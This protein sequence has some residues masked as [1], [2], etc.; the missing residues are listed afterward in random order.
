MA[1][2]SEVR[3]LEDGQYV[4]AETF[5]RPISELAS[6]TDY[7]KNRLDALG[8]LYTNIQVQVTLVAD[9]TPAVG[10]IVCV[11]PDTKYFRKAIASMDLYDAF[12]ASEK[13]FAVGILVAKTALAGTVILYGKVNLQD[14]PVDNMTEDP[15]FVNGQY[16]LSSS[17]PGKITRFPTG[18][19]ILLGFF[20]R[21]QAVA[22]P[23]SG[24]FA[25]LNPQHMDIEAH[26]HRTYVLEPR[27]AGS[28]VEENGEVKVIG[29]WPNGFEPVY[30]SNDQEEF[31]GIPR[32][33]IAGDY[34]S[35]DEATYTVTLQNVD[36]DKPTKWP[37]QIKWSAE[38]VDEG[39]GVSTIRFFGDEAPIGTL[40]MTVR[41]EPSAHMTEDSPYQGDDGYRVWTV[42]RKIARGWSDCSIH[43]SSDFGSNIVAFAGYPDEQKNDIKIYIPKKVYDLTKL[44]ERG[45][46]LMGM[47]IVIDGETFFFGDVDTLD[48]EGKTKILV[49]QDVYETMVALAQKCNKV[50]YDEKLKQALCI[51]D[52]ETPVAVTSQSNEEH[53]WFAVIYHAD[54]GVSISNGYEGEWSISD[55]QGSY[56]II[57]L[58]NGM[59]FK[60]I[61][62]EPKAIGDEGSV[63][64]FF[65]VLGACYRYNIEFDNDLKKH[66]PPVPARSGSLMLNGVELE[67]YH[68]FPGTNWFDSPAVFGIGDDSIYWRDN[69]PGRQ[70]WPAGLPDVD[71]EDEYRILFHFVSE[72]HSETGPVTSLHPAKDSPITIKRCGTTDDAT[73]GDL[74]LDVD[75]VL[76]VND[77]AI[78][79]YKAVKT[80]RSGKLLLGPMVEKIVAGPGI[81]IAQMAGQPNGQ[82][83][84]TISADGAQ[85]TGDFETVALENAKL[86]SIGMF[87]YVRFLR[88]TPGNSSNIPTGFVAKFHVPATAESGVYRVKFYATVFGEDSFDNEDAPLTAGIKMDYNILP[89]FNS[90]DDSF[91]DTAN[92][93]TGLIK[94][95]KEFT[96]DVPFGVQQEDE[97]YAYSA[98]DPLLVHNDSS[99][100][101][102]LGKSILALD[103]A[104]PTPDDCRSYYDAHSLSGTVFGVKPGYTVSVR[105]SRSDPSSGT[106]YTGAIGIL[107]LRWS[108]ELYSLV[109]AETEDDLV[110]QTVISLRKA[111]AK[112]GPM[113]NSY[114]LVTI[115]TRLLNAM[116]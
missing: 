73:V 80:S 49:G 81:S 27:P 102:V 116:K 83:V 79:G 109:D 47:E 94:P 61:G 111:A 91:I 14:M 18:P 101:P 85:Y 50:I 87:P 107:N 69:S 55:I 100:V 99:I 42:D 48:Q 13:A 34:T 93:K 86:E 46:D 9:D 7:L 72:F 82:G 17:T 90:P 65:H 28:A 19:R 38:G 12:T 29:Y 40:G 92:L 70:P 43:A 32:L 15:V 1:T 95:D 3:G 84:V 96:L 23:L 104:F 11:D 54:T 26:A 56:E 24:A 76:D 52:C 115:L 88:W 77:K 21:S 68:M 67:A 108:I 58:N 62:N 16:Y 2:W 114:D 4:D 41:L 112:S 103:H 30:D 20:S 60:I 97:T 51:A 53:V 78:P 71:I 74:E 98:Y 10:D 22:G 39:E 64:A 113:R 110:K 5:N 63:F 31:S 57:P 89:D 44:A 59:T 37:C 33:T 35:K 8:E 6:R 75:L 36:G 45:E 105:F 66:F 106:P 25:L